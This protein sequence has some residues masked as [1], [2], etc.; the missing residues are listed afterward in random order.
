[1]R[2]LKRLLVL[3]IILL[4]GILETIPTVMSDNFCKNMI[5]DKLSDM[6]IGFGD[7]PGVKKWNLELKNLPEK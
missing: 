2:Y 6:L 3:P 1:M 7:Y 4:I 5:P